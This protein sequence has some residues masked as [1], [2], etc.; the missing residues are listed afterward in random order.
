MVKVICNDKVL[1][2]TYTSN[3]ELIAHTSCIVHRN[4]QQ[5][6]I[7]D[8]F[9]VSQ[10]G[11]MYFEDMLMEE[12]LSYAQDQGLASIIAYV[13]PELFNPVPYWTSDDYMDW[14]ASYGFTLTPGS[15][16]RQRMEYQVSPL[17]SGG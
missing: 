14:Y 16:C 10:Y 15:F 3:D 6:E 9:A 12:V 5:L 7:I 1:E 13:G 17:Q 11:D 8:I 4:T 2:I